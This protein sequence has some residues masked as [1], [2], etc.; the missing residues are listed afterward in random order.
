MPNSPIRIA[1]SHCLLGKNVRYDGM[2]KLDRYLVQT[3]GNYF[4]WVPFCPE[5]ES[6]MGIPRERMRLEGP[7][8]N[9]RLIARPSRTDKTDQL[10]DWS[11]PKVESM[12]NDDLCG[13]IFKKGS[14]SCGLY[15]IR[16]FEPERQMPS[17]QGGPGLFAREFVKRHPNIP[18]EE[19]GRLHDAIL[20]EVFVE[21][22][23]VYHRWKKSVLNSN[24]PKDLIKFHEIHKYQLMAR[25]QKMLK[26]LGQCVAG[27]TQD[28]VLERKE[29]YF[30]LLME[31][32]SLKPSIKKNRNTMTH[33]MGYFKKQL[34]TDEKDELL[35]V[36]EQYANK[37]VPLIVP[38]TLLKHYV[39]KYQQ[40]YLLEQ[41]YLEPHPKELMIRNGV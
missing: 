27:V 34:S 33:V 21:K 18:M 10:M 37:L 28:N 38:I 26:D 39:R 20:R 19:E 14:P 40:P 24:S 31:T 9:P 32:I 1:I 8:D 5:A 35:D 22:V 3:Y 13:I 7:F 29:A 16:P 15:Q 2:H 25:S 41:T 30:K 17:T 36:I 23:F 11:I 6:G 4:E 12:G